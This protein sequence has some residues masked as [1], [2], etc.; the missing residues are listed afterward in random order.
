[1]LKRIALIFLVLIL[2]V[3]LSFSIYISIDMKNWVKFDPD[4]LENLNQSTI[5]YD[6]NE[7]KI[8]D[9][10]GIQNRINI[11]I[12]EVP[13]HVKN[14]FIA[15]ED[16]RF[17]SHR[18][19]DIR[20]MIGALA[21]N[22][23][24]RSFAQGASTITQQVVRN[25][26]LTMK[27]TISRKLQ[28]IYLALILD[29]RY[30][31][32]QILETYLNIIY[33]GKGAYG[34]ETASNIYFNKS[35]RDLTIAEACLLAGI[36][37]NPSKYSPFAN[38]DAALKRKNLIIDLMVKHGYISKK[39][40]VAA[41]EELITFADEEKVERSD[42]KFGYFIDRVLEEA[43][44]LLGI[45]DEDLYTGGYRIYTS[46]DSSLQEFSEQ[47]MANDKFFP[48]S[49][50]SK[51]IPEGALIAIHP[52]TGEVRSLI[53]G[54]HY[55]QGQ[56]KVLNRAIHSKRQPGSAIKPII[57][58]A[59]AIEYFDYT[60]ATILDDSPIDIGGYSPSNFGN[61]Y[62]GPVTL[63][64]ALAYSINTIAVKI[65]HN[66]G[67][68]NG[69][70]F[71]KNLGIPIGEEDQNNLAI[72]LG[73]FHDGITLLELARAYTCLADNGVYKELSSIRRIEDNHGVVLYENRPL[74]RNAVSQET[75]FLINNML[76]SAVEW[77][78]GKALRDTGIALAAKTGTAQLPK[79]KEFHNING[80][81]D[82]WIVAYNPELVLCIW[83]GFDRT[84]SENYL[85]SSA[86][87]GS[88]PARIAREIFI[89][90]Y[91]D[92]EAPSFTKPTNIIEVELDEK[93]LREWKTIALASALT[94]AEYIYKEFFTIQTAPKITTDYWT[95]PR[96]P[97][98]FRVYSEGLSAPMITF[99]TA[100]QPAMY[101][102]Y[103]IDRD[104]GEHIVV[105]TINAPSKES[106]VWFDDTIKDGEHYG[107][108]I[109]ATHPEIHIDNKPMEGEST[110]VIDIVLP[111][112]D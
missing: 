110:K 25:S 34:V 79:I 88:Y 83:M 95:A 29:K 57:S 112:T 5:I 38:V 27:K 111:K 12:A 7:N 104:T 24:S 67:L 61:T 40:G 46:I 82:A 72:G 97:E 73:G 18:G 56:R 58:F 64:E 87:G 41:K 44:G 52:P 14:A 30:S 91:K 75:A 10:H 37:K 107:Y 99:T 90:T 51:E 28:E 65:L 78:T 62:R 109:V 21:K 42:V 17:Y 68:D 20:R 86:V 106:I 80:V 69:T 13:D 1:M 92:K 53:G 100:S 47:V 50:N 16:I 33:F 15:V 93:S 3:A 2:I 59:P 84:T 105:H 22:I 102:I 23:S 8:M 60:A 71:A 85:P 48:Q 6:H 103:R 45:K 49:P 31:K 9:V 39:D 35:V 26:H 74:K 89:H 4:K 43:K 54:R 98:D 70:S 66:I 81:K 63:R 77:G 108:Y 55:P 19:I 11:S 101:N 94:P 96:A 36:P 76:Q 32:D